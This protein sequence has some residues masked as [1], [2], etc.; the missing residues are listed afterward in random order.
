MADSNASSQIKSPPGVRREK[1]YLLYT[2]VRCKH[3]GMELSRDFT[4]QDSQETLQQEVDRL[5]TCRREQQQ[6]HCDPIPLML[7]K[8]DIVRR[9]KLD[10]GMSKREFERRVIRTATQFAESLSLTS[11]R[12]TMFQNT[13]ISFDQDLDPDDGQPIIITD[14]VKAAFMSACAIKSAQQACIVM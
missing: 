9:Q 14:D 4:V 13:N 1:L 3:D 12:M 2:L 8:Y 11:N 7:E 6:Q 5:E 10:E